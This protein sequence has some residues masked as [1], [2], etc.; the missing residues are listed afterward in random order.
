M[1][2]FAVG[3][4][5]V[6][7]GKLRRSGC[8]ISVVRNN[9]HGFLTGNRLGPRGVPAVV[10]LAFEASNPFGRGLMRGMGRTRRIIEKEWFFRRCSMLAVQPSDSMIDEILVQHQGRIPPLQTHGLGAVI[11]R[12][13]ELIGF[14][15]DEA[16]KFRSEEHTSELQSLMRLSYAVFC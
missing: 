6:P 7:S 9:A 13:P 3:T 2:S 10:E 8:N 5:T 11:E 14:R 4:E 15:T 16:V 1:E 12:G